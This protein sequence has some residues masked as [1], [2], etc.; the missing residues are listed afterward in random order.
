MPSQLEPRHALVEGTGERIEPVEPAAVHRGAAPGRGRPLH[1]RRLRASSTGS[2]ARASE[3]DPEPLARGSPTSPAPRLAAA[4]DNDLEPAALSLRPDLRERLDALSAAGALG[5]AVSGSGPTCFGLFP[6]RPSA[7]AAA[8]EL[9][10]A[11][12]AELR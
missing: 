6:D 1:G 12:V 9:P 3:L 4:L 8:A 5:A 10:G 11:L 7:D 2:A